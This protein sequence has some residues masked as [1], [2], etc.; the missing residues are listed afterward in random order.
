MLFHVSDWKNVFSFYENIRRSWIANNMSFK[1]NFEMAGKIINELKKNSFCHS[2]EELLNINKGL[3]TEQLNKLLRQCNPNIVIHNVGID[4]FNCGTLRTSMIPDNC[5][6]NNS[7]TQIAVNISYGIFDRT[8]E[9]FQIGV[10]EYFHLSKGFKTIGDRELFREK[11]GTTDGHS[12]IAILSPQTKTYDLFDTSCTAI[13]RHNVA[14]AMKEYYQATETIA[15]AAQCEI[16]ISDDFLIWSLQGDKCREILGG[17]SQ[18]CNYFSMAYY[19]AR[20]VCDE[21]AF[22]HQLFNN[23]FREN[24]LEFLML[25][26]GLDNNSRLQHTN[27]RQVLFQ[28]PS[29]QSTSTNQPNNVNNMSV[30]YTQ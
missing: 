30:N 14:L 23:K 15:S 7:A 12:L 9:D 3:T 5:N 24:P 26:A 21:P 25:I 20:Q 17:S 11:T 2:K 16:R 27:N 22:I 18:L 1:N 6:F 13:A 10:K 28:I 29:N 19:I 8:Y 4:S